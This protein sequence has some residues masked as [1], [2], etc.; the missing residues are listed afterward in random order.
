[1][2]SFTRPLGRSS[3][4]RWEITEII[5]E[6]RTEHFVYLFFRTEEHGLCI[7][8]DGDIQSCEHDERIYHEMLVHPALASHPN[9]R[10]VL[11]MGGGEGAV[12]REVLRHP[13]IEHITMV[14]IDREFVELCQRFAPH[15]SNGAFDDRRLNL[16]IA[17]INQFLQS[18]DD[19]FDIII[20]DL[21]AVEGDVTPVPS[22]YD[23]GLFASIAKRL[24][25]SGLFVTQG[26]AI[27]PT[28]MAENHMVQSLLSPLFAETRS[29]AVPVPSYLAVW[30]F[31]L[32][33]QTALGDRAAPDLAKAFKTRLNQREIALEATGPEALA[34][35][36]AL[37]YW[38][39]KRP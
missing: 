4:V 5:A 20:D 30:S 34:A 19:T 31:V 2:L 36:F 37:P 6:G 21:T 28:A 38:A 32:A 23:Q 18:T 9:P 11:I 39:Q 15:W 27:A 12:A 13:S 3:T 25:E 24:T 14:D 17:D 8:L 7:A 22:L 26:G 29:Y 1:M 33:S 10:R 35:A 16:V